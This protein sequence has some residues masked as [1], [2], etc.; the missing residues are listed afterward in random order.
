V[1]FNFLG[2]IAQLIEPEQAVKF[3][4]DNLKKHEHFESSNKL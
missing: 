2:A 1:F 3:V 4:L